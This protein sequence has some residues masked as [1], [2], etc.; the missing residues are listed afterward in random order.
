[1]ADLEKMTNEAL[2]DD[3]LTFT[4]AYNGDEM[5]HLRNLKSELLRRLGSAGQGEPGK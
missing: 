4:T 2:I 3:V 5:E 1:M